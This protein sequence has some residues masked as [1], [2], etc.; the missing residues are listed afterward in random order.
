MFTIDLLKGQGVT[1]KNS[2]ENVAVAAVTICLPVVI[3]IA[4]LSFYLSN[5]IAMAMH[6]QQIVKYDNKIAE[7]SETVKMQ[8]AFEKER[9]MT[10]HRTLLKIWRP[11]PCTT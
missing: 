4:M 1:E 2:V 7:L 8:E 3:A 5:S 10:V 9:W 6:K 11:E